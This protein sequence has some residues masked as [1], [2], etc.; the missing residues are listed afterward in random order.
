MIHDTDWSF[1]DENDISEKWFEKNK[2]DFIN[3]GRDM[4][5]LFSYLK[6][7]HSRRIYGKDISLRKKITLEDL[8]KGYELFMKNKKQ[9]GKM[10]EIFSSIY[11]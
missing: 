5:L 2:R 1:D 9:E 11:V 7:A 3:Y 4:E 10:K 6:V 8:E